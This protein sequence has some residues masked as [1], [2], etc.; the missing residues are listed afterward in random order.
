MRLLNRLMEKLLYLI[1]KNAQ[2]KSHIRLMI[3]T[4]K[5]TGV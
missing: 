5:V 2:G 1:Q 4:A 3:K